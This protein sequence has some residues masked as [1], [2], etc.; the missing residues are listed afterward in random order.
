[1]ADTEELLHEKRPFQVNMVKYDE[2]QYS[3]NF[4]QPNHARK[5]KISGDVVDLS[6]NHPAIV[7]A[8]A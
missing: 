1:M 5:T 8:E 4:G 3:D 2:S 7:N 6:P